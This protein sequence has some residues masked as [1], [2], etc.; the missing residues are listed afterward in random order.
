[1]S[2]PFTEEFCAPPPTTILAA[3]VAWYSREGCAGLQSEQKKKQQHQAWM[4]AARNKESSQRL[5]RHVGR[6][7][8]DKHTTRCE[9]V[10]G[11]GVFP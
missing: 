1:M 10:G 7:P 9:Y 2:P 3:G 11:C 8:V 5:C 4:K 6:W